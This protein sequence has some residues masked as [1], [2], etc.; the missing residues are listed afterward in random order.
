[1]LCQRSWHLRYHPKQ[2]REQLLACRAKLFKDG[3]IHGPGITI[4][5]DD[6]SGNGRK[7]LQKFKKPY[8]L[9][10]FA[11]SIVLRWMSFCAYSHLLARAG[12]IGFASS[13]PTP[14]SRLSS[15]RQRQTLNESVTS[16]GTSPVPLSG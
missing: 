6:L 9:V 15:V 5:Y 7:Q 14:T 16:G 1:M 2:T 8:H 3:A 12:S 11:I 13:M 4:E 10:L